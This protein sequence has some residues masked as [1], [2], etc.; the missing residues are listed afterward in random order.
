[1]RL[2]RILMLN[3]RGQDAA[4]ITVCQGGRLYQMKGNGLASKVFQEPARLAE[5]LPGY[6][7]IS[8]VRYPTAGTSSA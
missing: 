5:N 8:H 3:Q 1:M 2:G 7:G 6:G 4:G